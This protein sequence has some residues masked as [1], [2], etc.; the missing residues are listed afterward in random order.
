MLREQG[1]ASFSIT[2]TILKRTTKEQFKLKY[3]SKNKHWSKSTSTI[4]ILQL[5]ID[6]NIYINSYFEYSALEL[7]SYLSLVTV[8]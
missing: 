7:F 1:W 3:K 5:I 4:R 2:K 8:N 6:A